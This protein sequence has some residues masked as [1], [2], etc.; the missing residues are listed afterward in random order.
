MAQRNCPIDSWINTR[1]PAFSSFL[2]ILGMFT[3]CFKFQLILLIS[4]KLPTG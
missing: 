2:E 4:E 3:L 1:D